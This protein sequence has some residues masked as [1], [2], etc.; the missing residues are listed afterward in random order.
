MFKYNLNHSKFKHW[1]IMAPEYLTL[2]LW[3]TPPNYVI[4]DY[5]HI[6]STKTWVDEIKELA[7]L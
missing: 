1:H 3:S 4:L 6:L 7:I 5:L 2:S